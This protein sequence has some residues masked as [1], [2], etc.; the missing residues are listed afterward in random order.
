MN[1]K[2]RTALLSMEIEA[3][4]KVFEKKEGVQKSVTED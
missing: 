2:A 4:M 3:G 1:L